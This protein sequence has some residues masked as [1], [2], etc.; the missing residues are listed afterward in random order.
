ME[1]K[2]ARTSLSDDLRQSVAEHRLLGMSDKKISALLADQGIDACTAAEEIQA[3]TSH[4]YYRAA[5]RL[6]KRWKKLESVLDVHRSL[7]S[8]AYGAQTVERRGRVSHAE[9]LERYYAANRPVIFVGLMEDWPALDRWNPQYF[10]TAYGDK[11]VEVMTGRD[12]DPRHEIHLKDHKHEIRFADYVDMVTSAGESNDFYLVSNNAFFRR[13]EM[14]P[15]LEDIRFFDEHLDPAKSAG[16]VHFWFGPAG[17]VTQLH[18]DEMNILMTQVYGR[19]RIILISPDQSH[20]LYNERSVYSEVDGENPDYERHPD[21]REVQQLQIVLE[22]GEALFLPVGWWHHVRALD[23][24]ITVT[25]TN[26][27]HL[28]KFDWWRPFAP[29]R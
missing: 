6:A 24:S 14:Q 2:T 21:F 19:K 11:L 18:H 23:V 4:P 12:Q 29:R 5:E 8:L 17:T 22:P 20:R 13:P 15:L 3:L 9:F 7:S 25:F 16:R 26:F 10:K 1:Q 28:N 27:V